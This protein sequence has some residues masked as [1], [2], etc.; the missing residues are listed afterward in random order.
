MKTPKKKRCSRCRH[1]KTLDQFPICANGRYGRY[2][3]CAECH[4]AYQ[5]TLH[6]DRQALDEKEARKT[7]LRKLGL[8]TCTSCRQVQALICFYSDP[9]HADG[10]QTV[11]RTC[12]A[13]KTENKYYLCEYGLTPEDYQKMLDAQDGL[14]AICGRAPKKQKFN[15]DHCH[16][17]YRIRA[18]LCVNCNTNLLPLVERYPQWVQN[19][20]KYLENPPAFLI[21]GERIVPITNHLRRKD[22]KIC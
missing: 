16:T 8:K 19:A 3:Y 20:F 2:N 15:V 1:Y 21:L 13:A 5:K 12:W 14:C 9:R 17:T 18:L 10:K 22:N 4:A 11:C 7:G 6:P